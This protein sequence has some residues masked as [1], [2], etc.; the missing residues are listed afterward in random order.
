MIQF[1]ILVSIAAISAI[2]FV[3][4]R[5]SGDD[6]CIN[7]IDSGAIQSPSISTNVISS[8][9][10]INEDLYYQR[11][12]KEDFS[13]PYSFQLKLDDDIQLFKSELCSILNSDPTTN[14]E[15]PELI[16]HEKMKQLRIVSD[17]S[18]FKKIFTNLIEGC[19]LTIP[20]SFV[21]G[22]PCSPVF[23][24]IDF[25]KS[26]KM[27]HLLQSERHGLERLY[28]TREMIDA[29]YVATPYLSFDAM[30]KFNFEK[31]N[32]NVKHIVHWAVSV[33]NMSCVNREFGRRAYSLFRSD[34]KLVF[35]IFSISFKDFDMVSDAELCNQILVAIGV[36]H[37]EMN[38]ISD[39]KINA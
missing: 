19:G 26:D 25:S 12:N 28:S 22:E 36:P 6:W 34:L 38:N 4:R 16:S 10:L 27:F 23:R 32:S 39:E 7:S 35:E 3:F 8:T 5:I 15:F 11:R 13:E 1:Y 33:R 20:Q 37:S 2:V 24:G 29:L 18:D 14:M 9:L 21:F 17:T 31:F 30:L